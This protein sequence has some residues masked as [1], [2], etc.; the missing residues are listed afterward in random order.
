MNSQ[1]ALMVVTILLCLSRRFGGG[2]KDSANQQEN[3]RLKMP[4][5]SLLKM[6]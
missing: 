2:A 4:K 5:L 3:G 1:I 6:I